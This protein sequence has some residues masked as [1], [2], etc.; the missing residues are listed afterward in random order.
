MALDKTVAKTKKKNS[1][2]N[3]DKKKTVAKTKVCWA[4]LELFTESTLT[5]SVS[6]LNSLLVMQTMAFPYNRGLY[7]SD[8]SRPYIQ[9]YIPYLNNHKKSSPLGHTTISVSP[10]SFCHLLEISHL[11]VW[12]QLGEVSQYQFNGV[13]YK[14][15]KSWLKT[16]I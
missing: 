9:G 1:S 3:K 5:L 14:N 11:Q 4:Q 2:Y 12:Q 7:I 6:I 15:I 10:S 16:Y 8:C 13:F